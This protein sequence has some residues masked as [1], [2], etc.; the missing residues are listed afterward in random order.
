MLFRK[1]RPRPR[2]TK[3]PSIRSLK[4]SDHEFDQ[5][6]RLVRD[7]AGIKLNQKKRALVVSRLSQRLRDLDLENFSQYIDLLQNANSDDELIRMINR[8]TTNKTDFFREQH[9]FT[10][11]TQTVLPEVVRRTAGGGPKKLRAWSAGCSSGEEPYSLAITISQF[12]QDRPGWDCKILATDLDTNMLA[13]AAAGVYD[14]KRLAPVPKH[15]RERYFTVQRQDGLTL[16]Q[17]K[18][19]IKRMVLFRKFNLMTPEFPLR[20][21]LD[22]IFCRNVMI[23][24]GTADRLRI[25]TNFHR[26]IHP[27]GYLF[28]GHS[29]SLMMVPDLFK[30]VESTIY[31]RQ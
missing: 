13:R 1:S 2:Q 20:N 30:H 26:L 18:P 28:V 25:V 7:H 10:F 19:E 17:V 14:S 23:Y 3:T 12:F 16:Y 21:Q 29:E 15:L 11:L 8:I 27:E 9:H 31:K 5:L 24:F 6:R 4:L 22:F